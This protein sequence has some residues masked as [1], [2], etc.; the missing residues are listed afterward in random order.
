MLLPTIHR[1]VRR[2][3]PARATRHDRPVITGSAAR[4]RDLE[5]DTDLVLTRAELIAAGCTRSRLQAQVD[6][7]RWQRV[8]RAVV[9]HNHE[10]TR[11]QRWRAAVLNCG[12]RAALTSFT[13]A[14]VAGLSGWTRDEIHVLV[15]VGV[16]APSV[17]LPI[18]VHRSTRWNDEQIDRIQ[19]CQWLGP[20]LVLAASSFTSARPACGLLAAAVQQRLI[21]A[22]ELRRCVQRASR[23]RHRSTLLHALDDIAMGAQALS[24]IDFVALCRRHRLPVPTMQAVRVEPSGRRRYLDA[25]WC[26]RDGRRV[27]VEVDGAVHTASMR[28]FDDQLRQNELAIGGTIVL[29]FPSVVVRAEERVVADQLRRVLLD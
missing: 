27:G 1:S 8:G 2:V 4:A 7:R 25:E 19:R 22:A 17:G 9:M 21:G 20:A 23:S 18:V 12:P 26:R 11:A 10:P 15:P 16:A 6:A 14:E 24:E 3:A 13:R 5:V 29:R 28:W